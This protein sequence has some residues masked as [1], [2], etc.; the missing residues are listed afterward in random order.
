[1]SGARV[2]IGNII[3]NCE[4]SHAEKEVDIVDSI[5]TRIHELERDV[6]SVDSH[7]ESESSHTDYT[8]SS[9]S[10]DF[11][12][13]GARLLALEARL[14]MAE[15]P[16]KDVLAEASAVDPP[17]QPISQKE[18]ENIKKQLHT[19]TQPTPDNVGNPDA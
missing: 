13:I 3:V 1:M 6:Y 14:N 17:D 12:S 16:L 18:L 11:V 8:H 7:S 10:G 2:I 19:D 5:K 4:C 9:A 15:E